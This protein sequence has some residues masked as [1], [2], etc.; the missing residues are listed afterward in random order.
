V[1]ICR[2]FS[3]PAAQAET[4]RVVGRKSDTALLT[5]RLLCIGHGVGLSYWSCSYRFLV[6]HTRLRHPS[7]AA[8]VRSEGG[9]EHRRGECPGQHTPP[10][11]EECEPP[12]SARGVFQE[13]VERD[14]RRDKGTKIRRIPRWR[15]PA[16]LSILPASSDFCHE[17]SKALFAGC[18][19]LAA[20]AA[21]R[22][23]GGSDGSD[24]QTWRPSHA[25]EL[26]Q[27]V[28]DV[29]DYAPHDNRSW[30]ANSAGTLITQKSS[31]KTWK[32][33]RKFIL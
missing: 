9:P 33:I 31:T 18:S 3:Q 12:P 23:T 15:S 20:C 21:R 1:R 7:Q 27:A 5:S 24:R 2:R 8:V 4:R 14:N 13:A 30:I 16:L 26:P 11:S 22:R 32:S 17:A 25:D 28:L 10:Q 29:I 19:H 6:P